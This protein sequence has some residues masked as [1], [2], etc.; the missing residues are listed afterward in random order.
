MLIFHLQS[1]ELLGVAILGEGAT[2]LIHIGQAVLTHGGRI[3]YFVDTVLNFL[4]LA[5]RY[6]TAGFGGIDRPD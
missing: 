3:D 1:R 5:E 2:E 4:M 6:K